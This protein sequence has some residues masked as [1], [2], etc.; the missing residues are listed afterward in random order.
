MNAQLAPLHEILRLNTR[1]LRNTLAGVDDASAQR[2]P[3]AGANNMAFIAVHLLDARA[4]MARY[5]GLEYR[6]PF[7]EALA[8]VTSIDEVEEFP[9]LEATLAA[10]DEVSE[11]LD[12]RLPSLSDA[13][14][15][16]RSSQEF[17]VGD[18]TVV[19]GITFLLQHESFHIGQLALLRRILGFGPMSYAAE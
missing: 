16:Q 2:R 11:L 14:V 12:R 19:G 18:P 3:G 4:W 5:L 15:A 6:H 10:W 7:E 13:E 1:L 8:S 17:P 9:A